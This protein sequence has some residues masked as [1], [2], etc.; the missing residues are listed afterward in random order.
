MS[1]LVPQPGRTALAMSPDASV[2]AA[3]DYGLVAY[4]EVRSAEVRFEWQV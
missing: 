2:F 4:W 3:T 1:R